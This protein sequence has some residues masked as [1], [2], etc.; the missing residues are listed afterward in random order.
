MY[1]LFLD[2][3]G[4]WGYP[5]KNILNPILCLCG[6]IVEDDCYRKEVIPTIKASKRAFFHKDDI[7][8]HRYRIEQRTGDFLGL[9]T[10][11][12]SETLITSFLHTLKELDFKLLIAAINKD[13]YYKTFGLKQVDP[14]LPKDLYSVVFTF[15]LERFV[16]F[17]NETKSHGRLVNESRGKKEDQAL[18][19]WYSLILKNG[20]QFIHDWQFRAVLPTSIEFKSKSE[21]GLQICDWIALPMARKI[22]HPDGSQDKYQEWEIYR[23]KIWV[24]N[25]AP[26]RGQVGFKT[27]PKNL[28]RRL[29]NMP[30]K[31]P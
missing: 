15:I 27:F 8:F 22:Q 19:Y 13:D 3:S 29:L 10:K 25:E 28:G 1:T 11:E 18:Q 6:C 5:N 20:T 14:Y 9:K 17:L 7:V 2:E 21:E 4:D 31:S 16:I 12:Q 23:T 24:G 30:L 26:A